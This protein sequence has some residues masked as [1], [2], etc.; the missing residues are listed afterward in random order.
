V[1]RASPRRVVRAPRLMA[2]A[3]GG[4]LD[5]LIRRGWAHPRA[6]VRLSKLRL[7]AA[8]LRNLV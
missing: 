3:Y 8:V 7:L 2:V 5:G 4:I 1:M 6:R